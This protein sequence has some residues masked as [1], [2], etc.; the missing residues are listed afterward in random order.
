MILKNPSECPTFANF[1]PKLTACFG[2][3][4][5]FEQKIQH[6]AEIAGID[7]RAFA[8]DHLAVRMNDVTTAM[9]W[10]ALLLEGG[11]LLKE[12]D[13]N[14]RPIGLFKLHQPIAFC[15]QSVS[16]IELPFPKGKIYQE[17]GWEHIEVVVPFLPDETVEQWTERVC[18][19]FDLHENVQLKLKISQPSVAGERL[20]NPSIAI[21]LKNATNCNFCC[22][23]LHPYDINAIICSEIEN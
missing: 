11:E 8:I 23:K 7:L 21:S 6:I 13:V 5:P 20:P 16:I 2:D 19:R 22:L 15:G 17:Q 14:G 10:K 1:L 3:I 18:K 12:S 4:A 9:Q